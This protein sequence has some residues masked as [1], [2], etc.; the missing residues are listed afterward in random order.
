MNA[1]LLEKFQNI[2]CL[3]S[4]VDGVLTNGKLYYSET[5]TISKV[6]H[7]HDGHGLKMLLEAGLEV[8]IIS[9]DSSP[10]VQKRMDKLG[11]ERVYQGQRDKTLAY[12][13]L[14]TQLQLPDEAIAYV[15]DDLLDLPVLEQ[16]GLPIAVANAVPQVREVAQYVTQTTGGKG[17]VREV[18]DLL[19]NFHT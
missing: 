14:K 9:A 1:N 5:G 13:E 3:I 18:C 2:R 7:V 4:D 6:F 11:I 10:L 12:A 8:A 17:A 16:V 19:L 15:G